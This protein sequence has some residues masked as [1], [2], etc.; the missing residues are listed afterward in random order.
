MVPHIAGHTT[1]LVVSHWL[2]AVGDPVHA[3]DPLVELDSDSAILE[4]TA[5]AD[6]VLVECHAAEGQ[7]VHAGDI[8]GVLSVGLDGVDVPVAAPPKAAPDEPAWEVRLFDLPAGAD[9]LTLAPGWEPF[10]AVGSR[11]LARRRSR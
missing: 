5:T 11:V 10:A 1:D 3:G 7:V 9:R 6:G 8:V 2:V 4:V